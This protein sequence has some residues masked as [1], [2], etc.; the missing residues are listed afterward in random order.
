MITF[1]PSQFVEF[2]DGHTK[3]ARFVIAGTSWV[4][5]YP[6]D[7]GPQLRL[8]SEYLAH[9]LATWL[10]VS[11]PDLCLAH[12]A[13]PFQ[14]DQSGV[15]IPGGLGTATRWIADARYPDLERDELELFWG[16]DKYLKAA[17]AMRVADTWTMNYDRRKPGNVAVR[18]Q[19]VDPEVYFL[20]FDQAFLGKQSPRLHWI[21]AGFTKEMLDDRELLSG[22]DGTGTVKSK[23]A[24]RPDHF[25]PSVRR[26][27]SMT[28]AEVN[29]AVREIPAEWG[30]CESERCVWVER[31]LDRRKIVLE[32]LGAYKP[33]NV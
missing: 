6:S 9:R 26:L 32:I 21:T 12:C 10:D 8:A 30:L 23:T 24:Q 16:Q 33:A 28:D 7:T 11:V 25:D 2:L 5:R 3:P 13:V 15:R 1:N 4:F 18:G 31:L 20:D 17:A 29:Q 27:C 19:T 22:F 14:P